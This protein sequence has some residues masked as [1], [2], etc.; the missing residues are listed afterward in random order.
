LR[1]D[2]ESCEGVGQDVLLDGERGVNGPRRE[3]ANN[4]RAD[5]ERLELLDHVSPC[6]TGVEMQ[7]LERPERRNEKPDLTA[8]GGDRG[9]KVAAHAMIAA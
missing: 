9:A 7:K 6:E 8:T 5:A 4:G 1:E 2:V 3:S